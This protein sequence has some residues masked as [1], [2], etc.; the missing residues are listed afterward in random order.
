VPQLRHLRVLAGQL[1]GYEPTQF[2]REYE[3]VENVN[4]ELVTEEVAS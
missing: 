2:S 1:T 4:S 3:N